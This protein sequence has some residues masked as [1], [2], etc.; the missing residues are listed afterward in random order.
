MHLPIAAMKRQSNQCYASHS[1][2]IINTMTKLAICASWLGLGLALRVNGCSVKGQPPWSPPTHTPRLFHFR[3]V[4]GE[5]CLQS[6]V[7]GMSWLRPPWCSSAFWAHVSAA[8]RSSLSAII[9]PAHACTHTHTPLDLSL[10][11]HAQ[12]LWRKMM[13]K[14]LLALSAA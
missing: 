4:S 2:P 10:A 14:Q 13:Q 8:A 12:T 9:P 6:E 1:S 5:H 11:V 7:P 3:T